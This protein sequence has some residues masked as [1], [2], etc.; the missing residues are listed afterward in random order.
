MCGGRHL[1]SF[2]QL[3]GDRGDSLSNRQTARPVKRHTVNMQWCVLKHAH[4]RTLA[5]A[6]THAHTHALAREHTRKIEAETIRH[7]QKTFACAS[8][9]STHTLPHPYLITKWL[10]PGGYSTETGGIC[11]WMSHSY[12]RLTQLQKKKQ[13]SCFTPGNQTYWLSCLDWL[14]FC[15]IC[16][17]VLLVLYS[18]VGYMYSTV[19]SIER[20]E[21]VWSCHERVTDDEKSNML[22]IQIISME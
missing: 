1:P 8:A 6:H 12:T 19:L 3:S 16:L 4:A 21:L 5:C 9:Y 22:S 7:I 18:A 10:T 15:F 2:S 17:F 20:K 13:S 14:I 11:S